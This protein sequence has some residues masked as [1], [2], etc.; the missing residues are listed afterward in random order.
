M[1]ACNAIYCIAIAHLIQ[2]PGN[3]DAALSAVRTYANGHAPPDV[4][5]WLDDALSNRPL[6]PVSQ[7]GSAGW[8]RHAFVHAFRC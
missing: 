1:Q 5:S 7:A 6:G 3:A 2:E 8:C 4:T